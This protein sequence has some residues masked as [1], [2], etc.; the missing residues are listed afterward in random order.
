MWIEMAR[1]TFYKMQR[2]LVICTLD[3]ELLS[4]YSAFIVILIEEL[5]LNLEQ[6]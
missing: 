2:R 6:K 5:N 1:L 4:I 3:G